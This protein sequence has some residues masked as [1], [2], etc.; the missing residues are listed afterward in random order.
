[1]NLYLPDAAATEALGAA[2]AAATAGRPGGVVYLSGP[3]GAG[4]TTLARGWLR[5]CGV[6]G[7]IRSPTYTLMEVY[8]VFGTAGAGRTQ[9]HLDLYRIASPEELDNLGLADF[10]PQRCWWLVEWPERAGGRL[11]P[12]DLHLRLS[13]EREGRTADLGLAPQA[14]DLHPKVTRAC[15]QLGAIPQVQP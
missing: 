13:L 5:A 12:A 4:K 10:P 1:M 6:T 8:E 14:A 2:L 11:P 3:L 7:A 15:S 9:M